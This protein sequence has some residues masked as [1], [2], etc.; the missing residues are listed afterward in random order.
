MESLNLTKS[1]NTALREVPRPW[2]RCQSHHSRLL[3][4]IPATKRYSDTTYSIYFRTY[5]RDIYHSLHR[6]IFAPPIFRPPLT[7]CATSSYQHTWY[8]YVDRPAH[9]ILSIC[10]VSFPWPTPYLSP[11]RIRR[12]SGEKLLPANLLSTTIRVNRR[13]CQLY[14]RLTRHTAICEKVSAVER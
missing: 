6:V 12:N 3:A 1:L 2:F 11:P 9:E 10:Y 5:M 14:T 7:L 8:V 4:T 13:A